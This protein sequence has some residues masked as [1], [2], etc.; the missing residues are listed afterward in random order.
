MTTITTRSGKGSPLTNDEVDANFTNL[1]DDKV[2]TSGDSMTGDLSFGDSNKAIFGAGSD[3]QIYHD[4][5]HSRLV[6]SGTGNFIIQAGEF[7]VNTSDDG[8]AMIKGNENGD[9]ELYFNGAQKLATTSTGIDVTGNIT[10]DGLT[11]GATDRIY[12]DGGSDT[13]IQ[14][15][16]SDDLRFF[17]G[18][19]Q[20]VRVR[21]SGT[22]ILGTV[23]ANDLTLSD[24]SPLLTLSD[25][26][27]TNQTMTFRESAG[28]SFIDVRNGSGFGTFNLRRLNGTNTLRTMQVL[29]SGDVALYA[30]DGTTQAFY[31]DASTSRLG[32]GTQLPSHEI[33]IQADS[34]QFRLEDSDGTNTYGDIQFNGTALSLITR[35]G[36]SSHGVMRFKST[37]GTD[38]LNRLEILSNGDVLFYDDAG[39]SGGRW[40]ASAKSL[41]IGTVSPA[42]AL[43]VH[44][45]GDATIRILSTGTGVSDDTI[46]RS[47]I[48]GTTASNYLYFGDADDNNSGQ[49]RYVHS[50]DS[51]RFY[52]GA[53]TERLRLY[54]TASIFYNG[55]TEIG[56]FHSNNNF[57]I[58]TTNP[59][60][61]LTVSNAGAE[62][63]EIGAGYT[64]GAN[65][66]QHYNRSGASW[67]RA[68]SYADYYRF[69]VS[70][71]GS[72][73]MTLDTAGRLGIGTVPANNLHIHSGGNTVAKISSVFNG[74]TTTGLYIDTVGDTS[75][76]RLLFSK[77]GTTR[78]LIGYSHNASAASESINFSTGSGLIAT[79]KGG[80]VGI[81]NS[82]PDTSLHIGDISATNAT[83]QGQ[84]KIESS[85]GNLAQDSGLEFVASSYGLGY[86]W[87]MDS[88][89]VGGGTP[90][91]FGV[92]QGA[93]SWTERVRFHHAGGITFN[94]DSATANALDDYEEG[95]WTPTYEASS[96]FTSITY[97]ASVYG[98]YV[99]VGRQVFIQGI[100]RTD[101][102]S[103]G[104]G[105]VE[106]GGLPFA[107]NKYGTMAIGYTSNFAGDY[108]HSI[109]TL[110]NASRMS[111]RY[112]SS[113]TDGSDNQLQVS[114]LA[115]GGNANYIIF[116]GTYY[117]DS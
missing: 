81:N 53:T 93:T 71:S 48:S 107:A 74:S 84:V 87:K 65:L 34:P 99:K 97:D 37:N 88:I 38:T 73:Q 41:G 8:E 104:S 15:S 110:N 28:A 100:V 59:P 79:M 114:D 111:I 60:Y 40:D 45:S 102:V 50:D 109:Y 56:R 17:V 90:L 43:D 19:S 95:T 96:A 10:T 108:P 42:V 98:Y 80:N 78:G 116:S 14:E 44:D 86:G 6:D 2:E 35:G 106:I 75:A 22:D 61:D 83:G 69:Y 4:G 16:G 77:S 54:S 85:S 26:D 76:A 92:R 58:G 20:A 101:A 51:M 82:A 64:S 31:W 72:A 62:G 46:L 94:G 12:L 70:G 3:L 113:L 18:G 5:S 25:S 29:T 27:G 36:A 13:F 24:T 39:A 68:D 115:T 23:T 66:M 112:M 11:I 63:L 57:G 49:M 105:N 67:V 30:N 52:A 33:H 91:V 1:N 55:V 21:A 117:T 89:D 7:R 32:L 47:Q 103:G 9:V